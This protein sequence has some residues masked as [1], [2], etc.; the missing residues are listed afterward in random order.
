M[1]IFISAEA[2]FVISIFFISGDKRIW[3]TLG[4]YL[5]L[6]SISRH[7]ILPRSHC[8]TQIIRLPL[9][10]TAACWWYFLRRT[11]VKVAGRSNCRLII[12]SSFGVISNTRPSR[13]DDIE[14]IEALPTHCRN[15]IS[16]IYCHDDN[17]SFSMLL[18]R[19]IFS[20]YYYFWAADNA[21]YRY[22]FM[23]IEDDVMIIKRYSFISASIPFDNYDGDYIFLFHML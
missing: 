19:A 17:I 1:T 16:G 8:A 13:N 9:A 15:T 10:T 14:F 3:H 23:L 4:A 7:Y 11:T 6:F 12:I 20:D 22:W 5:R 18:E 21:D 2:Y